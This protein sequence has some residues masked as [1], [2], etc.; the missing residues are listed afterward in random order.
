MRD[1]APVFRRACPEPFSQLPN[2]PGIL[3]EPE[4]Q[5]RHFAAVD[6][7]LSVI[8]ARPM[9]FR[10][11]VACPLDFFDH[12]LPAEY[13]LEWLHGIPDRFIVLLAWINGL[14]EDFLSGVAIDPEC[15]AMLEEQLR[16]GSDMCGFARLDPVLRVERIVLRE[17]WRQ[18]VLIYLYMVSKLVSW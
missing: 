11:D 1:V 18:A 15:A 10:Y 14:M 4:I 17:Y 6:V 16:S 3:R 9:C 8:S 2:L 7:L 13:G 5:R 12:E